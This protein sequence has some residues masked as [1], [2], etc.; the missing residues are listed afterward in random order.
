M[1]YRDGPIC[2]QVRERTDNRVTMRDNG[3]MGSELTSSAE[4]ENEVSG[5]ILVRMCGQVTANH[6]GSFL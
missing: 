1:L 6:I 4:A 3:E 2:H 5:S